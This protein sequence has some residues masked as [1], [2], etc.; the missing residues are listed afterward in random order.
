MV[1]GFGEAGPPLVHNVVIGEG[2]YFDTTGLEG[3][4]QGEGCVEHEGLAA[5]G[6][7]RGDGRL[8]IDEAEVGV[9]KD[10]GNVG[11]EGDPALDAGAFGSGSGAN[12]LVRDDIAGDSEGDPGQLVGIRDDRLGGVDVTKKDGAGQDGEERE[13]YDRS[14]GRAWSSLHCA[15]EGGAGAPKDLAHER[16][17]EDRVKDTCISFGRERLEANLRL[18]GN[19]EGV[20][21]GKR[22]AWG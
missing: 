13:G 5:L 4:W 1:A 8:H 16:T 9:M 3:L 6:V 14:K 10:V 22:R 20:S 2:D 18:S 21:R 19:L 11:E 17:H 15:V 7:V 12:G